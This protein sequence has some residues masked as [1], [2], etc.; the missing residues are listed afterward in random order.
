MPLAALAAATALAATPPPGGVLPGEQAAYDAMVAEQ[1]RAAAAMWGGPCA[2]TEVAV[3][4]STPVKITDHPDLAAWRE[5]VRVSGCGQSAVE[6]LSVGRLGGS[7]PWKI[8]FGLPGDSFAD[9]RLQQSTLP[10]ALAQV[11]PGLPADCR[12][13]KLGDVYLAARPGGVEILAPGATDDGR[14]PPG[15]PRVTLPDSMASMSARLDV[16]KAWM[17]VWPLSVCGRDRTLGV[18]FIPLK[19]AAESAT[20]FLPIWQQIEAHGPDAR[21]APAE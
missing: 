16:S 14:S 17:E 21:P 5:K 11:R 15:R 13:A 1:A 4:S 19:V 20:L 12:V 10:A 18:V 9:M 7:P 2:D 6:N 3:V 8:T